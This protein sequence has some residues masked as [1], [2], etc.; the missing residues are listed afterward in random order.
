MATLYQILPYAT[1]GSGF[2]TNNASPWFYNPAPLI[3]W[4]QGIGTALSTFGWTKD[5]TPTGT[6]NWNT[7]TLALNIRGD[8]QNYP[9]DGTLNFRG[10]WSNAGVVYAVRD[11]VTDGG[12]TWICSAGY[13]STSTAGTSTSSPPSSEWQTGVNHWFPF[14]FEVWAST[15]SPT[16][17]LRFEYGA[18]GVSNQSFLPFIRVKVG[19]ST[20]VNGTLGTGTGQQAIG[21]FGLGNGGGG[22]GSGTSNTSNSVFNGGLPCFFS[23]DSGNRFAML[24]WY[25]FDGFLGTCFFCVERSIGNTGSYC[26]TPSGFTTPYWTAIFAGWNSQNSN[27]GGVLMQSLINV[28]GT[29][30]IKSG[31]EVNA[32]TLSF[33]GDHNI[34]PDNLGGFSTGQGSGNFSTPAY[35]VWPLVGWVGNPMTAV[36]SMRSNNNADLPSNGA[37]FT[38]TMYG[39]SHTYL[40]A[41]SSVIFGQFGPPNSTTGGASQLYQNG[42]AMRYD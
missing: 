34:N 10:A 6:V 26:V 30:W 24:M 39:V 16:I 23:G 37:L 12:M 1:A 38:Q 40:A 9:A 7:V 15:G 29:T 20:D 21:S 27:T 41:R 35:P 32:T 14:L 36:L 28:T 25:P 3:A 19:T 13:T 17:Y 22:G 5:A 11:V 4:G 33:G 42:M 31:L 2:G 18:W 8:W